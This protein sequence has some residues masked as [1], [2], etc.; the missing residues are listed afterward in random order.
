MAGASVRRSATSHMDWCESPSLHIEREER[1]FREA[2]KR[3]EHAEMPL[4]P[5]ALSERSRWV[6]DGI[7]APHVAEKVVRIS[8]P[9]SSMRPA[10]TSAS[11]RWV[12][13]GHLASRSSAIAVAAA[14][15]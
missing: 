2:E 8:R 6:R 11:D 15:V 9:S 12:T 10:I 7:D 4:S 3:G 14:A 13:L 1:V 5:I